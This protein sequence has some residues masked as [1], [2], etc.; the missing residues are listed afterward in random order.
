[1]IKVS[2][3]IRALI[4]RHRAFY[5]VRPYH[6]VVESRQEDGTRGLRTIQAGFDVDVYG[7]EPTGKW[8]PS[9]DYGMAYASAQKSV[10]AIAAQA[11]HTCSIEVIP[12][13][14][15]VFVDTRS[16]MQRYGILRIRIRDG[17]GLDK[18][19][20]LSQ[21]ST[22]ADLSGKSELKEVER[23]LQD[24]GISSRGAGA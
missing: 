17:R 4:E 9:E 24:L 3:N 21:K 23:L 8:Q 22:V 18:L 5:E 11:T 13:A 2:E 20:E 15:S 19:A 12:F 7:L 6:V 1:V 10:E 16:Q 14:S